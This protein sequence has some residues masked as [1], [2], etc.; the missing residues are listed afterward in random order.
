[1]SRQ[2]SKY[3]STLNPE[4]YIL[5]PTWYIRTASTWL[6]TQ[7]SAHASWTFG[8]FRKLGILLWRDHYNKEYGISRSILES[9]YLRKLQSRLFGGGTLMDWGPFKRVGSSRSTGNCKLNG[10]DTWYQGSG[11][12]GR[13]NNL[14]CMMPV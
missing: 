9:P 12:L 6:S 13:L 4:P 5:N 1:M 8:G 14:S 7:T 3:L 2:G 11:G 10:Y